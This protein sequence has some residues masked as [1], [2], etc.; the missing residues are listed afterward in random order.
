VTDRQT[1]D[2]QTDWSAAT[3]MV[4]GQYCWSLQPGRTLLLRLSTP[5]TVAMLARWDLFCRQTLPRA[6]RKPVMF[7]HSFRQSWHNITT[8]ILS[9]RYTGR[10]KATRWLQ[11]DA[12]LKGVY[13]SLW[14]IYHTA[15]ERHLPYGIR[16]RYLPP[17]QVNTPQFN[18]SQA[19]RY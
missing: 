18:P 13:S 14:K 6:H 19:S 3:D 10:P 9:H 16:Q 2:K 7:A 12:Q 4:T 17:S 5:S 1:E 11:L 15:A 8:A